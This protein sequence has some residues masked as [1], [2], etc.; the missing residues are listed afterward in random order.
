VN[1]ADLNDIEVCGIKNPD[2]SPDYGTGWPTID[3]RIWIPSVSRARSRR[4]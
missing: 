3:V 1:D 2:R 4:L